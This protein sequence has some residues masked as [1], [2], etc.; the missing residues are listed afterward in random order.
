MV[1]ERDIK[2]LPG[3]DVVEEAAGP[4]HSLVVTTQR[5]IQ[6][7]ST[8]LGARS[9]STSFF[10]ENLD[11][12]E[13]TTRRYPK[14]LIGAIACLVVAMLIAS[15]AREFQDAQVFA[16]IIVF[17]ALVLFGAYFFLRKRAVVFHSQR[18]DIILLTKGRGIEN[19]PRFIDIVERAK[20]ERV[21]LLSNIVE[22]ESQ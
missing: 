5:L 15:L 14:L 21:H 10:L 22:Q 18:S 4:G 19:M 20:A 6:Q 1:R 16:M 2:L 17:V 3:E 11:S 12:I 9:E 8:Q 13:T 7:Y